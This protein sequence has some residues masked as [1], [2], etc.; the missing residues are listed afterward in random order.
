MG[1]WDP[2]THPQQGEAARP[3]VN[4]VH[5]ADR[6]PCAP[7]SSHHPTKPSRYPLGC[8]EAWVLSV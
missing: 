5:T 3:E 7:A 6:T 1:P 8:C 4:T 2:G